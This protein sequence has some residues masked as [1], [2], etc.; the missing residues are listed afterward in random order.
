MT[1]ILIGFDR[2]GST[3]ISKLLAQNPDINL[4]FQPFNSSELTRKQWEIW[5]PSFRDTQWLNFF[6][7]LEKGIL[8]DELIQSQWFYNHSSSLNLKPDQVNL[9]KDTKL[10]FK[11]GWLREN[12]PD[13][14]LYGIWR[15]PRAILR[16][17][18]RN[19]FHKNW[20]GHLT[21]EKI[22]ELLRNYELFQDFKPWIGKERSQIENMALGVAIRTY[23]LKNYLPG[24]NWVDFNQIIK[25]PNGYLEG[26]TN[27]WGV[28][29]FDYEPYLTNDYNI[30]GKPFEGEHL[31]KSFFEPSQMQGLNE[32]FAPILKD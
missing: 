6:S 24:E 27:Q 28:R 14:T 7:S 23:Y 1:I 31:W 17:L 29:S 16:S 8:N 5:D 9:I 21:S 19:D 11:A 12:F 30:A 26:L 13:L 2:S 25:D 10:H 3:M 20:Y 32:I 4:I 22:D 18:V 15:D